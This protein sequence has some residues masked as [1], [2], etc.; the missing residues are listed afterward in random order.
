M[1]DLEPLPPLTAAKPAV[2]PVMASSPRYVTGGAADEARLSL[3]L[4]SKGLE[5]SG[6]GLGSNSGID[7]GIRVKVRCNKGEGQGVVALLRQGRPM[8][9]VYHWAGRACAAGFRCQHTDAVRYPR[10]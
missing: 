2:T 3:H 7:S 6:L 9:R 5:G 10:I 4:A 8:R 1:M